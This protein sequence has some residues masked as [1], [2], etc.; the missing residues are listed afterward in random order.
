MHMYIGVSNLRRSE[1]RTNKIAVEWDQ[2]AERPSNNCGPIFYYNVTI[3]NLDD[4]S[5]VNS[6][7]ETVN[8]AEFSNLINGTSYN[9]SV[10]A[11][12]RVGTGPV[13]TITE[14]TSTEGE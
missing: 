5:D 13:S 8:S 6:S 9:I 4:V 11:V 3:V 14:T 7:K 2:P 1:I 12:N 10:A